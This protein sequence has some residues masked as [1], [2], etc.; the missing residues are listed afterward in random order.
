MQSPHPAH[1]SG[2]YTSLGTCS[3]FSGLWHH[4]QLSGH[5]FRKTVVRM[6]GPSWVEKRMTL[7][8]VPFILKS[9][10]GVRE[11]IPKFANIDRFQSLKVEDQVV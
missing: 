5:P 6:P 2:R 3:Q 8:M 9:D 7:K 10:M 1:R 11:N 4:Q